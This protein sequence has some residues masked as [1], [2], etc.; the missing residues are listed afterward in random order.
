M[1]S[2]TVITRVAHQVLRTGR[3]EGGV[4]AQGRAEVA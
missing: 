4:E 1:T 3:V 2:R